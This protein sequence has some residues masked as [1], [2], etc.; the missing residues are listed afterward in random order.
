MQLG[1]GG[2]TNNHNRAAAPVIPIPAT[3]AHQINCHIQKPVGRWSAS[4]V[5]DCESV[6]EFASSEGAEV[7]VEAEDL[8][9][10]D[11]IKQSISVSGF[12]FGSSPL[13]AT[14][15]LPLVLTTRR[16]K[17]ADGSGSRLFWLRGKPISAL[18]FSFF[19]IYSRNC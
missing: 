9:S 15:F 17:N 1:G 19:G 16:S 8:Y 14:E 13:I 6:A 2:V 10:F 3:M 11:L 18:V 7:M 4:L 12:A 5:W